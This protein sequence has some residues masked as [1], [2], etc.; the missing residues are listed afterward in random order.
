MC[1]WETRFLTRKIH[2]QKSYLEKPPCDRAAA[3][4]MTFINKLHGLWCNLLRLWTTKNFHLEL[5]IEVEFHKSMKM[6]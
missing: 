4:A 2:L 3:K 6:A 1:E 5:K